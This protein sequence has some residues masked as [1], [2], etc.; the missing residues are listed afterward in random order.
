M[1]ITTLSPWLKD[2][3]WLDQIEQTAPFCDLFELRWDL[4]PSENR[5]QMASLMKKGTKRF[6]LTLRSVAHGGYYQGSEQ[7]RMALLLELAKLG[8]AYLDLESD[9]PAEFFAKIAQEYPAV[10]LIA[11][12][13]DYKR[14]PEELDQLLQSMLRPAVAFYKIAALATTTVEALRLMS[15]AKQAADSWPLC[16]IAMGEP[17]SVSRCSAA[18]LGCRATYGCVESGEP[19]VSGQLP[20][21]WLDRRY[22]LRQQSKTTQLFGLIGDPVVHS[23]SDRSHNR[24]YRELGLDGLYLKMQ[25]T[26]DQLPL[27]F[28]RAKELSFMGLSVTMPLKEALFPYLDEVS[29]QAR[30]IG[31]V[32]T[33]SWEAGRLFGTNTDGK[34]ALEAIERQEKVAGKRLLLLGSGGAARAI[35]YEAK[36]RGAAVWIVSRR[37]EKAEEVA[38]ELGLEGGVAVEDLPKLLKYHPYQFLV[39]ATPHPLPIDE[40]ELLAGSVVME[41]KTRPKETALLRLAKQRGCRCVYGYEMFVAQAVEQFALWF[42]KVDRLQLEELLAS[43]C[44]SALC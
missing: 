6:L 34:G 16:V 39:N 19:L 8:P 38:Q 18:A 42:P 21:E 26:A 41:V 1:I 37:R 40:A 2:R 24:A 28:Q 15:W 35:G 23:L 13:H 30:A 10:K 5:E 22:R 4:L 25:L 33:L 12:H 3:G 32:N 43:E 9:L 36:A 17:G 7:E 29:D 11:S 14:V 27:F 44:L 20:V 31:A